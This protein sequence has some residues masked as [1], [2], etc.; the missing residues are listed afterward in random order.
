[1]RQVPQPL[2]IIPFFLIIII[3]AMSFGIVTPV[4]ASMVNNSH[5][6]GNTAVDRH[7]VYGFL[8]AISPL[9]YMIGAPL[10]GYFSDHW[11]RKKILIY[12][13][14]GSF[15]G[16]AGY[17][18][19]FLFQSLTLLFIARIIVGVTSGSLAVAQAAIA[20]ISQGAQKARNIGVIAVAM[21]IGLVA[22]PLL[23]GVLSDNTVIS[24]F[25]EL[26]PFYVA[27][28]LTI[29]SLFILLM[30]LKSNVVLISKEKLAFFSELR[31]LV[32]I[33]RVCTIF[34]VFLF[35]ELGWSL[36]Y[37]SLALLL[38]QKFH[39]TNKVVGIFI[40]GVGLFLSFFL[41]IGVRFF[42][43]RFSLKAII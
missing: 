33:R 34:I 6:L 7:L 32:K 15:L 22:G 24:W 20:D 37:S 35:F 39:L 14:I 36:Y 9:C 19:S 29:A 5:F 3:D 1:M 2:F 16:L 25:N 17:T 43:T 38:I 13:V 28:A 11:G 10:L 23:G 18:L 40:S 8:Q 30:I 31:N 4:L 12:C 27:I 21:T 26:T 42:T 41:I